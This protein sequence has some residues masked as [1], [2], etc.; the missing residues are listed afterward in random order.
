MRASPAPA[1]LAEI[2]D[3]IKCLFDLGFQKII[4]RYRGSSAE[5]QMRQLDRFVTEIVPKV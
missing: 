2:T 1:P 5:D 3:D 4:V